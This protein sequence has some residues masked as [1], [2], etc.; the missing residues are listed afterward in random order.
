MWRGEGPLETYEINRA[1]TL[2]SN[3]GEVHGTG[4]G[5]QPH[6]SRELTRLHVLM[7][8]AYERVSALAPA[9]VMPYICLGPPSSWAGVQVFQMSLAWEYLQ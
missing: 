6:V 2:S 4:R 9:C 3:T 8:S 7:S 5:I 1:L